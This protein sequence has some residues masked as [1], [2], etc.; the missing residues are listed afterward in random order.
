M[1]TQ[2]PSHLA[3]ALFGVGRGAIL[4]ETFMN[5]WMIAALGTVIATFVKFGVSAFL[6]GGV[7]FFCTSFVM[8]RLAARMT[9]DLTVDDRAR[10]TLGERLPFASVGFSLPLFCMAVILLLQS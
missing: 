3:P 9:K 5:H 6:L 10:V 2:P 7:I 1:S 8:Q 4:F